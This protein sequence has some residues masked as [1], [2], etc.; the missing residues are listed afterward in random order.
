[1]VMIPPV[2]VLI[3]VFMFIK[4]FGYGANVGRSYEVEFR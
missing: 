2:M 4:S 1:M 3:F